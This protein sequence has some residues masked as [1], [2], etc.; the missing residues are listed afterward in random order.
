MDKMKKAKHTKQKENHQEKLRELQYLDQQ[1]KG[2][3]ER[4]MQVEQQILEVNIIIE[5]LSELK[6]VKAGTEILVPLANG[7]F[8]TAEL[9]DAKMLKVNVGGGAVTEKS[10]DDTKN[11][12]KNQIKEIEE[13]KDELFLQLQQMVNHASQVQKEMRS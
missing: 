1:I 11:M 8:A 10:V 3:E 7:I 4:L 9:K 2:F 13:Y 6:D 5:N 12:L